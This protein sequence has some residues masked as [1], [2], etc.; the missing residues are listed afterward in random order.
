LDQAK[1]LAVICLGIVIANWYFISCYYY[2]GS[3][4]DKENTFL[5]WIPFTLPLTATL[6]AQNSS[7]F[8]VATLSLN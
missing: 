5:F 2:F 3:V 6:P 1:L 8:A 7:T 4:V